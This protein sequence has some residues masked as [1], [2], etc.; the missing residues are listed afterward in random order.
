[1]FFKSKKKN[2]LSESVS[3]SNQSDKNIEQPQKKELTI[4]A[5][6]KAILKAQKTEDKILLLKLAG[7]AYSSGDIGAPKNIDKAIQKYKEGIELGSAECEH[8][9]GK[10]YI[11]ENC[12]A[13]NDESD[14]L[15]SLGVT[16]VCESYKHGYAPARE[17][18]QY[19]LDS[20]VFPNFRTVEDLLDFANVTL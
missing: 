16:I 4:E 13:E 3:N 10:L 11:L 17:T 9:M 1:M 7:D 20:G 2:N 19:L 15:F 6:E 14:L 8:S 12:E 18:L 5:V